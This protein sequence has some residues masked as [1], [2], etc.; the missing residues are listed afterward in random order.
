MISIQQFNWWFF[1]FFDFYLIQI[2]KRNGKIIL[3]IK[4][5]FI[6]IFYK[7]IKF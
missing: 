7:K 3:G 1:Y 5:I 2:E 4:S 6:F